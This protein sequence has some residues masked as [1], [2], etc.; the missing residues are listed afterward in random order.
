MPRL[1]PC[2]RIFGPTIERLIRSVVLFNPLEF[3][4]DLIPVPAYEEEVVF[5]YTPLGLDAK[6]LSIPTLSQRLM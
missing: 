6:D 4:K 5:R 2:I 1:L 3:G